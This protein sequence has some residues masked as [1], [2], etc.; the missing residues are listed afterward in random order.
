MSTHEK[1]ARMLDTS[2]AALKTTQREFTPD[3]KRV[4]T[5]RARAAEAGVQLHVFDDEDTGKTFYLVSRWNMTRQLESIDAAEA[6]F[7]LVTGVKH[8]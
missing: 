3:Q 7:D 8:G 2:E 4:A 5:L 6:W 1:A